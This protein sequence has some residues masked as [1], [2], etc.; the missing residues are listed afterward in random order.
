MADISDQDTNETLGPISAPP[1]VVGIGASAGGVRAL[2]LLFDALPEKTGAAFVVVVHLDPDLH[3]E[4][5]NILAA[6]THMPVSQVGEPV[7]LQADHV[8]VIPPDRRLHITNDEIATAEFDEPRGKRAPIDLFFRSLA[9][10]TGDGCAVILT[11][12]G[13]DGVVGVRAVKESGGIILVQDPNEAEFPSMP[14][15]AIATGIADFVLP[16]RELAQRLSELVREKS[17]G[18]P[19]A[20]VHNFSEELLRRILAHVR[21]RTGHDFSKYKR[22]TILRR[23]ARRM[24]VTR[25]ESPNDY[26]DVLRDNTDEA[27][28]L[29][30]DLLISV[31]SFFRDKEAFQ[32]LELQVIPQLFHGKLP[33]RSIRVWV[34]GCATGEEAYSISML[35]LEQASHQDIRPTIQVFGSD[36]DPKALTIAREG[37]Y[38]AAIEADVSED[39]LRRFFVREADH[40]RVRQELRDL[41]LF[42]SHSLLKDPPFSRIDLIACRNL[43]IYLD[44]ELQELACNTFHYALN[45]D[46]FLMLGTSESADNPVGLF[47]TFDRKARIYQS[48]AV[49]GERRL[50]PRLLGSVGV[51]HEQPL[52]PIKPANTA[53]L[54]SEVALHRQALERLAP[55]SI[56]VDQS[57]RVLH[58]SDN[59]GRFLQPAGG[60]LSGNVVDLVRPELRF[61]LR[62]A[63]H[64]VFETSQSWLSLPIPVRFN[65]SPHRVLMHVKPTDDHDESRAGNAVV[66][67]IEGG[68]VELGAEGAFP[69]SDSAK[70]IVTRLREEL[71]QTQT[72]LRTT[73]E[74]SDSANEELRAANEELQSINEEYRSTSEEL[75]TSKEELQSINEE[76]QTVN[77]ELKLKLE[78]VSRAHSDL[79]NLMAATDFGTL[80]LDSNLR[81]KRFTQQVTELFSITSS[82]EGRPI[83]DFS[84]RLEYENLVNDTRTVLANLA[85]IRH[86]IRSRDHRWYDVRLRPYRT[87]DDKIDGVVLT[88]VDMTDR[89]HA[90]DALRV[91]ER[92]LRQEKQ[93]VDLSRDPIFIWDFDGTI[94]D[95]NRGSEELYGY[96]RDEA[97]GK[98]KDKLLG[99]S[100]ESFAALRMKLLDEGSWNGELKHKT[101]DGRE[102]TIESRIILET[103]EGQQL[104]LESTRDIT[105]RKA[106]DEQQKLLLGEL[107]HRVK[108]TLAVVQSIAHQTRRFSKSDE[109]F[110]ERLDGRLSALAAA[111]SL[112]VESDWKG[113]D[114]ATL[115]RRQMKPYLSDDPERVQIAGEP[116]FLPAD[117]ATPFGLVL[118]ELATNAAKY[119]SFS[120]R[121]GIVNLTWTLGTPNDPPILTVVWRESGGPPFAQPNTAGFGTVLIEKALPNAAVRRE[122]RS[123]GMVCTIAVPLQ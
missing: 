19:Q 43:L 10:Q 71:L 1:V 6:R 53:S 121:T 8:Y 100:K 28:A 54:L 110:T 33:D 44:R 25:T 92:R 27:Q 11:G 87:V 59:A 35:L 90:E 12:A 2:Q 67:F 9:E 115:A 34:P 122:F 46:G 91:S 119:G 56:L 55:P 22:A 117:L 105:E 23:I 32:T 113:A 72:R 116:V 70:E 77:S 104:A 65:G 45:P 93:L 107:T 51:L 5:P 106:W 66:L 74:E 7:P 36:I 62:S 89:R 21:V 16:V 85:P 96:S 112:L 108:N 88:F 29:L 101:K 39:R 4:M 69:E 79:Q 120:R 3:S 98:K 40:Y 31:T 84:H 14:R 111:H 109:D 81:I 20:G 48:S 42:A 50:L 15:S 58:M 52:H 73:R 102:L 61:E 80:F 94:V 47:R 60:P 78:A 18:G 24:Q 68:V 95:W 97:V 30:G 123:D 57:H 64:R 75:E 37:Q 38:P 83:S 103:I 26:Y 13:S 41:V 49:Q 86:E 63:L 17:N 82:D 118:H 114:L 76:L 99:T